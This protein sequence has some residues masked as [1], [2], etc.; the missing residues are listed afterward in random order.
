[1]NFETFSAG[2]RVG[3]EHE[4]AGRVRSKAI[5]IRATV[6][7]QELRVSTL[8][9]PIFKKSKMLKMLA[10]SHLCRSWWTAPSCRRCRRGGNNCPT[11]QTRGRDR[12]VKPTGEMEGDWKFGKRKREA[13][14]FCKRST[15]A[16]GKRILCDTRSLCDIHPHVFHN[17]SICVTDKMLTFYFHIR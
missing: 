5:A 16:P 12:Q 15:S 14:I 4:R 13:L 6:T 7:D 10:Q 8:K 2:T 1:M 17:S 9:I 3:I 11:I